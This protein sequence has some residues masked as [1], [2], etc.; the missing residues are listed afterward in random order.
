MRNS[1]LK[2][3]AILIM[4]LAG[5]A[6]PPIKTV[7]IDDSLI[8]E[9]TATVIFFTSTSSTYE[10]FVDGV[11]YG[12]LDWDVPIIIEVDDG[13]H[14]VWGRNVGMMDRRTDIE[15]VDGQTYTFKVY[16]HR[17]GFP[18]LLASRVML[19]PGVKDYQAY[20]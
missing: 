2:L 18:G 3:F 10:I 1:N 12:V 19:A 9:N 20:E 11:S 15:L 14:K 8:S 16:W 5:C 4:V 17:T 6:T 7:L 13:K